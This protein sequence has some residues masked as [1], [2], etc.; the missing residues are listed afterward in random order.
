MDM[1]S[2]QLVHLANR[3]FQPVKAAAA[4]IGIVNR[5]NDQYAH[6]I[7]PEVLNKQVLVGGQACLEAL[8]SVSL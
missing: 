5:T 3:R 1:E 2:H 6:P 7:T 8:I 4:H